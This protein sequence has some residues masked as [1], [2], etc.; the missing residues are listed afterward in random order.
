MIVGAAAA[1]SDRPSGELVVHIKR[2][3][4]ALIGWT[5][6]GTCQAVEYL[7]GRLITARG[8]VAA[9]ALR[10]RTAYHERKTPT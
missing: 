1:R 6:P 7:T 10:F 8:G 2:V 3:K 9:Y 4:D 5:V